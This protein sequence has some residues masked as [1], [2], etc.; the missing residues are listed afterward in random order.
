MI[1]NYKAGSTICVISPGFL[2]NVIRK[3]MRLLGVKLGLNYYYPYNHTEKI[4]QFEGELVAISAR[5]KGIAKT[6][7]EEYLKDHP[8][9]LILEPVKPL[10]KEEIQKQENYAHDMLYTDHREYQYGLLLAYILWIKTNIKWF[11]QGD[12]RVVC[13]ETVARFDDLVN[14]KGVKDLDMPTIFEIVENKHFKPL[15]QPEKLA[16]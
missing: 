8:N 5:E 12:K 15:T 13:Y 4:I 16:I 10:T 6:P 9:H 14:R 7:I 3:Y 1:K 11:K 2:P